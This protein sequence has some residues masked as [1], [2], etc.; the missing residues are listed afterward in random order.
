MSLLYQTCLLEALWNEVLATSRSSEQP[1]QH[2]K[3]QQSL[4]NCRGPLLAEVLQCERCSWAQQGNAISSRSTSGKELKCLAATATFHWEDLPLSQTDIERWETLGCRSL[5][6]ALPAHSASGGS[7]LLLLSEHSRSSANSTVGL[8]S[9]TRESIKKTR[10]TLF[11][12]LG[13]LDLMTRHT[14]TIAS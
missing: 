2:P 6:C 7:F 11:L 9:I 8:V 3:S 13:F 12:T 5:L 4:P 1:G 14:K 10:S